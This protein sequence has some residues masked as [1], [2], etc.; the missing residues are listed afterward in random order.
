MKNIYVAPFMKVIELDSENS[1]MLTASGGMKM[2]ENVTTNSQLSN[3]KD[4]WGN[5]S[6]WK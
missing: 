3:E 5:E 1:V 4:I 2:D 6:I